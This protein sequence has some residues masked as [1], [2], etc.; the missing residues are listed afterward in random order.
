MNGLRKCGKR[1]YR[2][3]RTLVFGTLIED[4]QVRSSRIKTDEEE[5]GSK[6]FPTFN[7]E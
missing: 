3:V 7:E 4:R 5:G 6:E 1:W 2:Q